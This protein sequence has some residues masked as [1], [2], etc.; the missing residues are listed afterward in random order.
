MQVL[1]AP[2][3]VTIVTVPKPLESA[4][5][6]CGVLSDQVHSHYTRTLADLPW[7]GRTVAVQVRVKPRRLDLH[8][9]AQGLQPARAPVLERLRNPTCRLSAAMSRICRHLAVQQARLQLGQKH[10]GPIGH[11][12]DPRERADHSR[13]AER[14]QLRSSPRPRWSSLPAAP[15]TA[16]RLP[17]S[18]SGI[19]P[20]HAS[21][22]PQ[23]FDTPVLICLASLTRLISSIRV[24]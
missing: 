2:D 18:R 9:A 20:G 13:P 1:S 22:L 19:S 24:G 21:T 5:P 12:A 11:Q 4:C 6:L 17:P 3:R 10:L 15:S 7:Q 23:V 14:H 16:S 8:R